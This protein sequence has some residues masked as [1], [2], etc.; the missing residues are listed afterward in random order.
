MIALYLFSPLRR[1]N[2]PSPPLLQTDELPSSRKYH[3]TRTLTMISADVPR[4]RMAASSDRVRC[5]SQPVKTLALR[6]ACS[7]A[8][9]RT[10]APIVSP[11]R[12]PDAVEPGIFFELTTNRTRRVVFHRRQQ[13]PD[14]RNRRAPRRYHRQSTSSFT[15][16]ILA[17][18]PLKVSS[19]ILTASTVVFITHQI[20]SGVIGSL[21]HAHAGRIEHRIHERADRGMMQPS[22]CRSPLRVCRRRR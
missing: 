5:F 1:R 4:M 21:A 3:A 19:F 22:R 10:S 11:R 7:S 8:R 15:L 20:L 2:T 13:D 14:R 9:Q 12:K 6:Q 18:C 16:L 17:D